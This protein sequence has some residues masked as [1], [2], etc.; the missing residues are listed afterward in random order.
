MRREKYRNGDA[1]GLA[2][3]GCDGCDLAVIN[4]HLCHEIGCPESW[5]DTSIECHDCGC[6]FIRL[7]RNGAVCPD[8]E[9]MDDRETIPPGM[10]VFYR[11]LAENEAYEWFDDEGDV[12]GEGW[13]YW[14]CFPGCLPDSDPIG[15]FETE[16]EAIEAIN[17]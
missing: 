7:E 9:T 16:E 2:A 5:R 12:Y 14:A 13:Y 3:N 11:T 10:E 17:E 8:C 1:V 4:G 6:D 15:P